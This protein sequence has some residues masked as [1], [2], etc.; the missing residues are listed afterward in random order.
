M[1]NKAVEAIRGNSSFLITSHISPDGDALGSISALY[2]L[3][4]KMGKEITI[5][6]YDKIPAELSFL[7]GLDNITRVLPEKRHDVVIT[8]DCANLSRA[9]A[10]LIQF[11]NYG[12]LIN[13]D[14]HKG[15]DNFGDIN[16]VDK[17]ICSTGMLIY[18]IIKAA[19]IEIDYDMAVAI[20]LTILVDSGSFHY[21]NASSEAFR[22][23]A[24]MIDK[25]VNPWDVAEHV[26][27][28]QPVS[29]IN[30][31][32]ISLEQIET[33]VDVGFASMIVTRQMLKETGATFDMTDGFINYPRS[34]HGIEIALLFK[35]IFP[36]RYKVSFRSKKSAD[37][38][39]IAEQFG[40]GGH[41]NAAGCIIDGD[42]D[43]IK[44]K[45][46]KS[47]ESYLKGSV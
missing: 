10:E 32:K 12:L 28:N 2:T 27:E 38:G 30:L 16:I 29:R 44:K 20:Y 26:Y 18:K 13:V 14:H 45:I 24:E 42:M 33:F 8:V 22:I 37:V 47:V 19:D 3:L 23:A 43:K 17:D 11:E 4:K 1:I 7:N 21:S 6:L 39:S 41:K 35:E 5:Y 9:G 31:L 15:N 34:I 36:G 25:G 40:G 46:F